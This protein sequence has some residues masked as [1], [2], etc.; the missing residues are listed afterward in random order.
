MLKDVI[1]NEEAKEFIKNQ[2]R[3]SKNSGTYLFYGSEI[4]N[5][6][7]F[8]LIFAK[9]LC[10]EQ[11]ENDFCDHCPTC[12]KINKLVYADLEILENKDGIRVSEIWEL[13]Q[14]T[15]IPGYEGDKKIFIIKDVEKM[16]KEASNALLKLIE[17]PYVGNFFLLLNK[18]LNILPTIKSRSILVKINRKKAEELGVDS[19]T[20]EFFAG[21]SNDICQFKE[22]NID[23]K[24][25]FSF[26]NIKEAIKKYE[27]ERKLV[28][29]INIYKGIRDFLNNRNNLTEIDKIGFAEQIFRATGDKSIFR[30]IID[31]YIFILGDMK[32]LEKRLEMKGKMRFNVNMRLV[33]INLFKKL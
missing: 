8:A 9:G 6:M 7:E 2:L 18:D 29:K 3:A 26:T 19:F 14:K 27:Q 16:R 15:L 1:S 33:L 10:C 23:L 17:E 22:L 12:K 32:G 11:K 25:G 13:T 5:L 4:E 24:K 21:R 30:E 20:Y 28:D 31:Y